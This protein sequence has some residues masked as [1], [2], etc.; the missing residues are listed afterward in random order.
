MELTM[1]TGK[2]K[3]ALRAEGSLLK[4]IVQIG[5]EGFAENNVQ[6]I[7]DAFNTRELIKIKILESVTQQKDEIA[8][9]IEEKMPDSM[10]VQIIGNNILLYRPFPEEEK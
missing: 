6:F 9:I 8:R 1:L 5:K 3:R 4:P 10:V 7:Y 2:Q